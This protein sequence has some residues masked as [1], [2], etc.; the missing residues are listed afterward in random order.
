MSR[1]KANVTQIVFPRRAH[2]DVN[3]SSSTSEL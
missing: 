1:T 3:M 2:W